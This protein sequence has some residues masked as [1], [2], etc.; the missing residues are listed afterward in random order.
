[1]ILLTTG[2]SWP[3]G[4]ERKSFGD[5]A[6]P[7]AE[8]DIVAHLEY[9]LDADLGEHEA[10]LA[11]GEDAAHLSD[12]RPGIVS[13]VVRAQASTLDEV[14]E[15]AFAVAADRASID[16]VRIKQ[17]EVVAMARSIARAARGGFVGAES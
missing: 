4:L 14:E 17:D 9:M 3:G 8:A 15:L 16:F 7:A 13:Y 6:L 11:W 1:M 2:T 5:L 10:V 12:C